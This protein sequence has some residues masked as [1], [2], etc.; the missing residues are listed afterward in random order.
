MP[1]GDAREGT[2]AYRFTT[3]RE[4]DDMTATKTFPGIKV[5][6]SDTHWS[7]PYDLWTSRAPAKYKDLVPQI[8]EID[9]K[10]RW[11][12]GDTAIAPRHATA[13]I[14]PDGSK[15][16]GLDFLGLAND[17]V[18]LACTSIPERLQLMD[19]LGIW[20]SVIYPN[21]AGFGSQN[22]AKAADAA[23]REACV[24]I[25]NDYMAELQA[26]SN[27]RLLPMAM[28]P[29]WDPPRAAREIERAESMGLR[30]IVTCSNPH[31][32]G[33]PNLAQ[34][35][36]NAVWEICEDLKMPIN[37][38]IGASEGDI[39]WIGRVPY[40][41][42]PGPLRLTIG[43]SS[44]FMGN[45]RWMANLLFTDVPERYPDLKFVSVESGVGWIPFFLESLDYQAGETA[46]DHLKHMPMKPSEYFRRQFYAT[47]WFE[48]VSLP[49]AVEY[50][51]ADRI[52]FETDF[53]HPTCLYPESMERAT[54]TIG[55]L[56]EDAQHKILQ[57]NP[58]EL[59]RIEA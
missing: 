50:L 48:S 21:V 7:E 49:M 36:W 44:L 20:V 52:M 9:G 57:D 1:P 23:L 29:W 41:T 47:F 28:I 5:V 40:D 46:P 42:W 17:D 14:R 25:Y 56:P 45:S 10:Q 4:G 12:V 6:D 54:N 43:G 53:P 26:D 3:G 35:E 13:A 15:V 34:P 2:N 33:F 8:K 11:V 59:Y 32:S 58:F 30:G 55:L 24:E 37:F 16:L 18:H 39:D 31:D 38:H 19:D 22:F 51:G 27:N